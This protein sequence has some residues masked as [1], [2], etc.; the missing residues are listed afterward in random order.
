MI[1]KIGVGIVLLVI[2]LV[3]NKL[4]NFSYGSVPHPGETTDEY[5]FAWAG[6][7]LLKTGVPTAWSLL[8]ENIYSNY[9]L[10]K[11]N[12]DDIYGKD[13][14]RPAFRLV[15]PWFDKPPLFALIIGEYALTKG[16]TQ[17]SE[18]TVGIIRRPMLWI[19]IITTILIFWL[20]V[21]L[22]N[23]WV[24]LVAAALYSFI[25]TMVISSR[26]TLSENGYIPLFLG[27]I[28]SLDYYFTRKKK[29]YWIIACILG[30]V[31]ILFKLSAVAI[32]MTIFILI[33]NYEKKEKLKML[34]WTAI[35]CSLGLVAFGIYGYAINWQ[36]FKNAFF[37]QSNLFYGAGSEVFFNVLTQSKVT[38]TKFLTDGWILLGWIAIMIL[39][40]N[41]WRKTKGGSVITI[42]TLSYLVVF[43]FFGGE[44]YGWYRFPFLPFLALAL[45]RV[46]ML[47]FEKPN[48][49]VALAGFLLPFGTTVHKLL[50][51]DKF[52]PYIPQFRLFIFVSLL[53]FIW[54]IFKGDKKFMV[55]RA[56][57]VLLFI[58]LLVLSGMEIFFYTYGKWFF[59][60]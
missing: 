52:Q 35:I 56:F 48:L 25:P 37:F 47:L 19:A 7:S 57:L 45:A 49:F 54:S 6:M 46:F 9:R 33:L 58:S 10:E 40:F 43:I 50:E 39:S 13:P 8:A 30:A 28:I 51:V 38:A 1:K 44:S 12:V 29:I 32:P 27:A 18:T 11:I 2:I 15:T 31:G 53:I 21:R 55:E 3:G 17:F 5:A 24:G 20:G 42:A 26:L 36:V 22:Y 34:I 59:A 14:A 41:E 4:R 16:I 60:T 23:P